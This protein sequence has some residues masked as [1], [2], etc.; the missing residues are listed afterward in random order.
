LQNFC[1]V[2]LSKFYFDI[3]KDRLYTAGTKSV[4]RR[5]VQTVL[6]E[7]TYVLIHM[8]VPVTPHLAEDIWD[9]VPQPVKRHWKA[10]D[11]ILLGVFP[12]LPGH[13][14]NAERANF[15]NQL[16]RIRSVVT[17]ALEIAR[18]ERKKIGSSLEAQVIL[19]FEDSQLDAAARSLG[20]ELAPFFITS[21]A[22][23]KNETNG[24]PLSSEPLSEVS[25]DGIKVVV[26]PALGKKC[27]R[28][29]KF[30][31]TV[32]VNKQFADICGDCID[33]IS[34]TEAIEK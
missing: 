32:G 3:V 13:Y 10:E 8:L 6:Q 12:E 34:E 16:L 5:A 31:E 25:E 14:K 1:G 19:E 11:S 7:L 22:R 20:K 9:Y 4:S 15:W 21:Q 24:T 33:A 27:A 23:L 17:K 29:W 18:A 26:L 30:V 28:C 2:E